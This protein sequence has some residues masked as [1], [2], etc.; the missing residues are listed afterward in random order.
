MATRADVA[1]M[2]GVSEST[3]SY[4]LNGKRSISQ[5][6]RDRVLEAVKK[7]DY[8]PHFAAGLLAG[9]KSKSIALSFGDVGI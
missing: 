6:T 8:K 9:A 2:A 4:A 1:K 5:E 3:V 7:L